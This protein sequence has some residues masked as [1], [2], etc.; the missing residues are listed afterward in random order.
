MAQRTIIHPVAVI[1][2]GVVGLSIL[3]HLTCVL[4]LW[5]PPILLEREQH[6]LSHASGHNSG[7]SCTGTDVEML[8]NERG[9]V[10]D[11][12]SCMR[13]H[14]RDFNLP[15]RA[16]GSLVCDWKNSTTDSSDLDA[17]LRERM[18]HVQEEN[19]IAGD[20]DTV[21]LSKGKAVFRTHNIFLLL[22]NNHIPF[23]Q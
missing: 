9:L 15:Y 20:N 18:E 3:R 13:Q 14:L 1:G 19:L 8:T 16:C 23:F 4:K 22:E 10:R 7:I 21:L 17:R 2:G 6:L 11:S 12:I 5:P